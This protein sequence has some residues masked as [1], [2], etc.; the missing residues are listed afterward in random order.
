MWTAFP[1]SDYYGDSVPSHVHQPTTG[2]PF[3]ALDGRCQGRS[4]DGSHVHHVPVDGGGAQLFPMQPRHK[5]AADFSRG[6]LTGFINQLRSRRPSRRSTC[7]AA[8]PKSARLEP[9]PRLSGFHHWFT[10]VAPF[11]SCLPSPSR[12]AIPVRPGVVRAAPT[13]PCVSR[14]RLPSASPVCRDRS[15]VGLCIPPGYAAP[16]G[17]R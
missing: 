6:L 9:V 16:H 4:R 7:T 5:Y 17:A 11:P 10:R 14:V 2:L 13:F 12:L 15:A 1:S 8:R 3:T